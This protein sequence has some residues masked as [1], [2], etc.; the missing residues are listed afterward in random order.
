MAVGIRCA[1]RAAHTLY[2]QKLALTSSTGRGYSV[3][4]ARSWTKAAEFLLGFKQIVQTMPWV[5][6]VTIVR[7]CGICGRQSAIGIGFLQ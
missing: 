5:T 3:G 4:I 7:S 2:P 6:M 1:D